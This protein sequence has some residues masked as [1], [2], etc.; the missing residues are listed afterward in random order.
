MDY[1]IDLYDPWGRRVARFDDVPLVEAEREM[2]GGARVRGMLPAGMEGF[3]PGYVVEVYIG[4][5]RFCRAPVRRVT[6]EWGDQ[7]KLIIDRFLDFQALVGFEA[8]WEGSE[9]D[10]E[11][12]GGYIN[13]RVDRIVRDL[14]NRAPGPVHYTIAHGAFPDGA[15]REHGKFLARKTAG[16]ELP[17]QSV[18]SGHWV[19]PDRIDAS[20]AYAKDGRTIA[21]LIVDGEPWPDLRLLMVDA[22]SPELDGDA[23]ARH[24]ETA[25][26]SPAR[27][28]ASAYGLQGVDAKAALQALLDAH[29]VS[30]L[31]LNDGQDL[32]GAYVGR[33]DGAGRYLGMAHGGGLNFNAAQIEQGYGGVHLHGDGSILPPDWTL[34]EFFSYRGEAKESIQDI[35]KTMKRFEAA[36]EL[37]GALTLLAYAAG[38]VWGMDAEACVH[39]RAPDAAD[40]VVFHE[41]STTAVG[42]GESRAGLINSVQLRGHPNSGAE[43]LFT[44]GPS[45]DAF[46]L[47]WDELDAPGLEREH[48]LA[49]LAKGMLDD[50]AYPM[51]EGEV[52]WFE[53]DAGVGP[54]ELL[55]LRGE[56]L[57]ALRWPVEGRWGGRFTD[58]LIARVE[59]VTHR[60]TGRRVRTS[61]ALTSPLRSAGSPLRAMAHAHRPARELLRFALDE[62]GVGLDLGY[63]VD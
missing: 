18:A 14:V 40:R 48:E 61:A 36:G 1:R 27:Y 54:G 7:Q 50:L 17:Y 9:A 47:H 52:L 56:P 6:P 51:V 58:K 41:P 62:P 31:E 15:E 42:Y 45:V 60:F 20:E 30:F 19:G 13:A 12:S 28:A 23:M 55:A 38:A 16:G 22:E 5:Q 11:V 2:S 29:G 49:A 39:F 10:S 3:G 46:G 63:H 32:T 59:R 53:G 43:A 37:S 35:P 21:G 25:A 4:G 26:W 24:P 44:R 33:T 34:K 8:A 57:R